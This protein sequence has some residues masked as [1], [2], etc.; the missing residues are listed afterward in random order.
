MPSLAT[1]GLFFIRCYTQYS[2]ISFASAGKRNAPTTVEQVLE[3][4]NSIQWPNQYQSCQFACMRLIR[5]A[6]P[7]PRSVRVGRFRGLNRPSTRHHKSAS[8]SIVIIEVF[9]L[10]KAVLEEK[11]L[12]RLL[13][14]LARQISRVLFTTMVLNLGFEHTH[15]GRQTTSKFAYS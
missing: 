15:T 6:N 7:L 5:A 12:W 3:P 14:H 2:I 1:C 11:R 13:Q 10:I 4:S 9:V 8:Y